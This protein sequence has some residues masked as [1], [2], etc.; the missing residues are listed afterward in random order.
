[1]KCVRT[2]DVFSCPGSSKPARRSLTCGSG[3]AIGMVQRT[4]KLG[5]AG[6]ARSFDPI[7]IG[8]TM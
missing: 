1:M 3:R 8:E 5:Y 7:C 2:Y 6:F 4:G